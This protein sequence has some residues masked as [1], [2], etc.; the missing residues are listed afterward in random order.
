MFTK[1]PF[2]WVPIAVAMLA[3][4][5]GAENSA[6]LSPTS[7]PSSSSPLFGNS[8]T[9]RS[10][11]Q[12]EDVAAAC[13]F[14]QGGAGGTVTIGGPPPADAPPPSTIVGGEPGIGSGS[15][16]NPPGPPPAGAHVALVGGPIESV[17]G[18]CPSIT[19]TIHGNVVRT[20]G[21]TTFANASCSSVET[22]GQVGVVGTAEADGSLVASCVATGF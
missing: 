15:G 13:G 12:Q 4:A 6:G 1:R 3:A 10:S 5:C 2:V 7:L 21:D 8:R 16:L 14:Q 20:N 19:F 11:A 17:T 18:S 9:G 22:G